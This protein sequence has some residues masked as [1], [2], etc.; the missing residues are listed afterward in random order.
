MQSYPQTAPFLQPRVFQHSLDWRFLLPA[1][2]PGKAYVL[3]EPDAGLSETLAHVGVPGANQLSLRAFREGKAR[4]A[5][6]LILPFGLASRWVGT[7]SAEQVSFFASV[8][9]RLPSGSHLLIGFHHPWH[10]Q[11]RLV[12]DYR[13]ALPHRVANQLRQAGYSSIKIFGAMPDLRIPEYIFDLDPRT[14]YFALQNRFRRKP[15]VLRALR[16]LSATAGPGQLAKLLPCYFAVA[17]V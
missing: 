9:S 17:A 7:K 2:D 10:R 13:S 15:A 6:S 5:Q 14:V 11:A 4:D 8:R 12:R 1:G 3:F 16:L